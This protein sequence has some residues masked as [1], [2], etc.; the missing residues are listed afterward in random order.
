VLA[1][2]ALV[3]ISLFIAILPVRPHRALAGIREFAALLAAALGRR[4]AAG[5]VDRDTRE[6]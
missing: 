3:R 1:I 5:A 2:H 6:R 4:E